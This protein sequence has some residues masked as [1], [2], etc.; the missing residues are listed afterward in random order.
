MQTEG[1]YGNLPVDLGLVELFPEEMMAWLYCP[2]K[3]PGETSTTTPDNLRGFHPIVERVW[4][5]LPVYDW[6]NSY[7]YITAKTL[8][9]SPENPGNRPG[10]HS[11]GFMT[12]DLN[13]IWADANPTVFWHSKNGMASF[14]ADHALSTPEM[15][16]LCEHDT[17]NHVT[18]PLKHVLR[19]DETVMHKVAPVTTAG[20]RTFVKVSVSKN[21]Y[22]LKG[23]SINHRLP[24]DANYGQRSAERNCPTGVRA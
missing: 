15:D 22:A 20:M 4:L 24:L 11:D 17:E 8:F 13:Y 7:I 12:D 19:L 5:D 10:W 2:I 6:M 16:G 14:S 18:Y 23:N 3:R 21:I 1:I 9:V